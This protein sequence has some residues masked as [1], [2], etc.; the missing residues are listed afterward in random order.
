MEVGLTDMLLDTRHGGLQGVRR[1]A[2]HDAVE[3][4]EH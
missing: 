3:A 4:E 2:V 1:R